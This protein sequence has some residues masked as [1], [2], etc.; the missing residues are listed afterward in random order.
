VVK[1]FLGALALV[2][3]SWSPVRCRRISTGGAS[4]DSCAGEEAGFM[5][6]SPPNTS[7]NLPLNATPDSPAGRDSAVR[8]TFLFPHHTFQGQC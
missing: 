4:G 5:Y 7:L 2:L 1:A 6:G 8:L 3:C